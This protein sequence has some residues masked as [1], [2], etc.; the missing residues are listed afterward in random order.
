MSVS[1]YEISVPMFINM[2]ENLSS[3][4]KKAERHAEKRKIFPKKIREGPVTF[5][6]RARATSRV[7]HAQKSTITR[8]I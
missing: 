7:P 2:L 3:I 5:S 8:V 1:M 6:Q 4:L